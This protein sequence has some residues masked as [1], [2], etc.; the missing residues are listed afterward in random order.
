MK[1]DNTKKE[2]KERVQKFKEGR[3]PRYIYQNE[4]DKGSFQ[5]EMADGDVKDLARRTASDKIL[6][7]KHLILPEIQNMIDINVDLLQWS[8]NFLI[9]NL[10]VVV[11]KVRICQ[12]KKY[13]KITK[14]N[15]Q[16]IFQKRKVSSSFIDYILGADLDDMQLINKFDK[17][18]R[19]LLCVIDIFCKYAWVIPLK[20]KNGI[21]ITNAFQKT[22]K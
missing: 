12:A 1:Q 6:H 8:I 17:Q 19:F 15:Y 7:I 18:F 5:N 11:L 13:L 2:N 22:L 20:Y 14:T 4:L 10:L 21:A 9:K 16:K 3:D